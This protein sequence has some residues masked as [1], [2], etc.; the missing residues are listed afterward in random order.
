MASGSSG[1]GSSDEGDNASDED[2]E[3]MLA[4]LEAYNRSMFGLD[5]A[6]SSHDRVKGKGKGKAKAGPSDSE[7]SAQ[8]DDSAGG[9]RSGLDGLASGSEDSDDDEEGEFYDDDDDDFEGIA[10]AE[11]VADEIIPTVVYADT[12]SNTLPKVSKA[13]YKRFMA[14]VPKLRKEGS[15]EL[16]LL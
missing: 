16:T 11:T 13:D 6:P 3:D 1:D 7:E 9:N 2:K 14:S 10:V 8:E 15:H 4:A 12:G 5:G